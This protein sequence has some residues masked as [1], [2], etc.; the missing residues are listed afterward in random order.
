MQLRGLTVDADVMGRPVGVGGTQQ[1][2]FWG[3]SG[4]GSCGISQSHRP[5]TN[6]QH[7]SSV[8]FLENGKNSRQNPPKMRNN[9]YNT[10]WIRRIVRGACPETLRDSAVAEERAEC[11]CVLVPFGS[12]HEANFYTVFS[13]SRGPLPQPLHLP[14]IYIYVL[15]LWGVIRVQMSKPVNV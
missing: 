6:P 5:T 1:G 2:D 7:F 3:T 12:C 14:S 8:Y 15:C 4:Q 9:S 13:V 10:L 11:H